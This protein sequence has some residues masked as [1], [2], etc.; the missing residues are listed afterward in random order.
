MT[1]PYPTP[2]PPCVMRTQAL[3]PGKS[4]RPMAR[5]CRQRPML[6]RMRLQREPWWW[7]IVPAIVVVALVGP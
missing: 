5:G 7:L 1:K 2:D 6:G 3:T 4:R